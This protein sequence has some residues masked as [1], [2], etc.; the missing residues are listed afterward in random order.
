MK[1]MYKLLIIVSVALIIWI[2]SSWVSVMCH[3]AGEDYSNYNFFVMLGGEQ[4]NE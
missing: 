1:V 2:S 4:K 3:Y